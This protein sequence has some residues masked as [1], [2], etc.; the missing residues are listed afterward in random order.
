MSKPP[1][2]IDILYKNWFNMAKGKNE[3]VDDYIARVV[4]FKKDLHDIEKNIKHSELIRKFRQWFDEIL[5]PIKFRNRRSFARS[6]ELEKWYTP[7]LT[8]GNDEGVHCK[9]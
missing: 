1:N 3:S 5:A 4:Q 2:D 8:S 6:S 7:V 9:T